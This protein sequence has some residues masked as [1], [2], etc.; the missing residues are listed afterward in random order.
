MTEMKQHD[1]WKPPFL[2]AAG[3]IFA[4]QWWMGLALMALWILRPLIALGAVA[5]WCGYFVGMKILTSKHQP[6]LVAGVNALL[7]GGLLG[8]SEV[9]TLQ[10][11]LFAAGAG[12]IAGAVTVALSRWD[13][14][15]LSLP[16]A[17]LAIPLQ[18]RWPRVE[19]VAW[20]DHSAWLP[21]AL[22]RSL[23]AFGHL[24][25]APSPEAGLLLLGLIAWHSRIAVTL[26]VLGLC[27][28]HT[29]TRYPE[30]LL[31]FNGA[32]TAIAL[33]GVVL[34][35]GWRSLVIAALGAAAATML[36]DE[37]V[38]AAWWGG[39]GLPV[40][41]LPFGGVTIITVLCARA[42]ASPLLPYLA[43]A[44]PEQSLCRHT[45]Y[46]QRY[47]GTWR[48]IGIPVQG[49]WT[50]WQGEDGPWTHRGAW[51]H[52]IDLVVA[53]DHGCTFTN[54]GKE[55][56]DFS[57]WQRPVLAPIAGTVIAVMDG[58]HDN[59]PGSVEADSSRRFGN[60]VIIADPRGFHVVL[61]HLAEGTIRVQTGTWVSRGTLLGRCG[62][63]GYSPQP[64]LHLHVQL[65]ARLGAPT[66]P[67]SLVSWADGDAWH[68]NAMP[69]EGDRIHGC[70]SDEDLACRWQFL[71]GSELH[72]HTQQ[73]DGAPI[74][75]QVELGNDGGTVLRSPRGCLHLLSH[76]G[77]WYA[78]RI[79]GD[80]EQMRLAFA[81][82]PRLP[83]VDLPGLE[84][85]DTLPLIDLDR[86]W[87]TQMLM[88]VALIHPAW[89]VVQTTHRRIGK[90]RILTELLAGPGRPIRRL[91]VRLDD[92]GALAAVYDGSRSLR[93]DWPTPPEPHAPAE[94]AA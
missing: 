68:A 81:A 71:L 44:T 79:D 94:R 91:L 6:H 52:A 25:Y 5:A 35:P 80:D 38:H 3:F 77:T 88:L 49:T 87:Q 78:D 10:L 84:W 7:L 63:S 59:K 66:V 74:R 73:P 45:A 43:A 2:A 76:E 40:T 55:C 57:C 72:F 61:A 12:A 58:I 14:P 31:D 30:S 75:W 17:I 82:L 37:L 16:F 85:R 54:H 24:L 20:F 62:N 15:V 48:T 64:H 92:R 36:G 65:D 26:T 93:R 69:E 42:C 4:S 11:P 50:V 60:Y 33:G 90:R 56:A 89:S 41:T 19:N 70:V 86:R 29:L 13:I 51:R 47:P 18:A 9:S 83:L 22:D 32:L 21:D 67:F 34:I 27:I 8:A 53:D 1:W 23:R 28:A 39:N 46:R